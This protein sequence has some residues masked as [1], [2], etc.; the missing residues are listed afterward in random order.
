MSKKIA[1]NLEKKSI[2]LKSGTFS[3]NTIDH[4]MKK[5]KRVKLICRDKKLCHRIAEMLDLIKLGN[6][7][8]IYVMPLNDLLEEFS[9]EENVRYRLLEEKNLGLNRNLDAYPEVP[10]E[11]LVVSDHLLYRDYIEEERFREI[12]TTI[13][14][15]EGHLS[16]I[17]NEKE[18]EDYAIRK[19]NEYPH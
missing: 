14:H 1:K 16:G 12:M 19:W 18:A 11:I 3:I 6:V 9:G 17:V 8:I 13:F 4:K 7:E 15:E 5:R 10:R 2:I